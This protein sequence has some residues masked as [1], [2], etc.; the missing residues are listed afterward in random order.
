MLRSIFAL[1]LTCFFLAGSTL[2]PL[3]DFSL[4]QDLPDMYRSYTK[5]VAEE[6][7]IIDF[8]GD[9]LL[10][11]KELMGHNP[12]DVGQKTNSTVQFQHQ[13]SSTVFVIS[14]VTMPDVASSDT[15]KVYNICGMVLPTTNYQNDL[16]RPPLAC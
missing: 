11:G 9:Y 3:G 8:I 16:L 2:F 7:D 5:I 15:I 6:P 1:L 10:N 12:H 14:Y 13:A 4:M